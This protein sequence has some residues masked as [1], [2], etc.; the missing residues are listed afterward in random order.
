MTNARMNIEELVKFLGHSPTSDAFD[1]FLLE[2]GIKQRPKDSSDH[3]ATLSDKSKSL[4][5]IFHS[6][7][8][9]E[10][11][12]GHSPKTDGWYILSQIDIDKKN[13]DTLPFGLE[14][15]MPRERA[16]QLLGPPLEQDDSF[17]F[18]YT[19]GTIVVLRYLSSKSDQV[20]SIG[21]F[22]PRL[23]HKRK[24]NIPS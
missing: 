1:N 19:R 10:E 6:K 23:D 14:W 7:G 3:R 2:S 17:S 15:K 22:D 20:G 11:Y 21:I 5:L 8:S 24:Y 18:F 9:Y 4:S 16:A 12:I 13:Q